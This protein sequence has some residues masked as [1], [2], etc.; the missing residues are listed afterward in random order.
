MSKIDKGPVG[1]TLES[2]LKECGIRDEVYA[3]A[4]KDVA[5]V[6]RKMGLAALLDSWEL[7]DE[8]FPEIEDPPIAPES[9]F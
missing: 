6:R 1:T 7:L 4:I 3:A 2:Y 5:A 9:E 8:E